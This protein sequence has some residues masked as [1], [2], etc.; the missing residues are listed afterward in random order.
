[1]TEQ[2]SNS[3]TGYR[4]SVW[5][6]V[7]C[8]LCSDQICGMH[9]KSGIPYTA[10]AHSALKLGAVYV[11]GKWICRGCAEMVAAHKKKAANVA[12]INA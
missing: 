2:G 6:E 8:D 12:K 5:A 7:N 4:F 3:R 9:T 11:D 10:L 1:M